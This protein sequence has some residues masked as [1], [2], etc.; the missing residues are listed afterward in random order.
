MKRIDLERALLD[1]GWR[2][3]RHGKKH[4]VWCSED[5]KL[6]ESVPRHKEINEHTARGILKKVRQRK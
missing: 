1:A 3:L 6:E 5:G 2:L 4:D